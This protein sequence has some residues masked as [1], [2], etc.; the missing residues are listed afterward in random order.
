M[1]LIDRAKKILLVLI[2]V[3]SLA[4][5]HEVDA[6]IQTVTL[7]HNDSITRLYVLK[8][9]NLNLKNDHE[10]AVYNISLVNAE[11]GKKVAN[12]AELSAGGSFRLEFG[13]EG[14]Y[15][16]YYSLSSDEGENANRYLLIDVIAPHPA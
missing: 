13:R 14:I 12:V 6:G 7:E 10:D 11:S 5:T 4:S 1:H 16:L 9:S 8:G 3:F 2:C 15:H